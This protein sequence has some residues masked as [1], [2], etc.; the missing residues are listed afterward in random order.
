MNQRLTNAQRSG[1][2]AF[3][4]ANPSVAIGRPN[5]YEGKFG[6]VC[7]S[8]RVVLTGG[9][10]VS[11]LTPD[12]IVP[13]EFVFRRLPAD[14]VFTATPKNPFQF[15]MGQFLVPPNMGFV[16]LDYNFDIYRP[17]GAAAGD[18]VPLEENRLSTQVGWDLQSNGNR[19]GNY[20]FEVNPIP[21]AN[22]SSGTSNRNGYVPPGDPVFATEDQFEAARFTQA[23]NP[24][25]DALSLMPQRHHR[26]GLLHVP[27]PW[28]LH[29]SSV[30][31]ASCR[32]MRG[33][34]IPIGFFECGIFGIL[35]PDTDLI[36][37][38]KAIAACDLPPG[39]V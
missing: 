19:Q 38:Q 16:L 21:P 8:E 28:V 29:T 36:A 10:L 13:L 33:I 35:I 3:A 15:E 32:I 4:G 11:Y 12:S 23:A 39:G 24:V 5:S 37:M 9:Q 26:Q 30:L 22:N 20:R 2:G 14:G 31:T 27:A 7:S 17:S 1:L 34:P 6:S 25:G 18:F